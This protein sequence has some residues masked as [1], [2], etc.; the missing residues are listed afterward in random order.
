MDR[1]RQAGYAAPFT[2][3][4]EGISDYVGRYLSQ[5]DRYR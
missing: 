3:L 2:P 1:L 5:A 4:E